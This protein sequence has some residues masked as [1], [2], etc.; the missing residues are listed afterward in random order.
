MKSE[1]KSSEEAGRRGTNGIMAEMNGV[2]RIK[3]DI[4]EWW[5]TGGA[6]EKAT[7]WRVDRT[8]GHGYQESREKANDRRDPDSSI[9][10]QIW[11]LDL[12]IN[13]D[14]WIL[15]TGAACGQDMNNPK[16]SCL[17]QCKS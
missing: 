6:D 12:T 13:N 11:R 9:N 17:E 8:S 5:R 3:G 16:K 4:M 15:D 2:R 14:D 1:I 10:R 7:G